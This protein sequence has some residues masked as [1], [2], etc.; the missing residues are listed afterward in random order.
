MIL[1]VDVKIDVETYFYDI[2]IRHL[3]NDF[4]SLS[5]TKDPRL[6]MLC[7]CYCPDNCIVGAVIARSSKTLKE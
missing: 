6:E 3:N 5:L 1:E 4:A 7:G 2:I